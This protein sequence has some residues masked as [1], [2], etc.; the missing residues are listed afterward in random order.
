MER[1]TDCRFILRQT[2][3]ILSG[4][5][6]SNGVEEYVSDWMEVLYDG[7]WRRRQNSIMNYYVVRGVHWST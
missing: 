5:K 3:S 2:M 6:Y 1:F 7:E 4:I